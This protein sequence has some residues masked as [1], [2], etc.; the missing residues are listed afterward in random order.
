[1]VIITLVI[2]KKNRRL[3]LQAWC[4]RAAL[5]APGISQ[6]WEAPQRIACSS[7]TAAYS[8]RIHAWPQTEKPA[9][10]STEVAP[11]SLPSIH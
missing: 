9:W 2:L 10:P 6:Y 8:T 1:M 3:T 4:R 7:P 11:V 5:K